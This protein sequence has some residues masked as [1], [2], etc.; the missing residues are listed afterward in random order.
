MKKFTQRAADLAPAEV[1]LKATLDPDVRNILADKRLL[2]FKEMAQEAGV[3]DDGLFDELTKGFSLTGAMSESKQFPTKLKPAMISVKQLR[4]SAVWAKKM[5][6][7]SCQKVAADKDIAKSV[8]DET[9]Q[10]LADGWVKGPSLRPS[11]MRSTVVVGS[12]Q[13]DLE[14]VKD[15]RFAL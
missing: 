2:L 5:I 12:H 8:Y 11:W 3:G 13:G 6:H 4:E 10:Q 15:R 7:A 1:E 9:M 14:S